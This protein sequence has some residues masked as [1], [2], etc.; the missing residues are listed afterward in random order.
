MWKHSGFFQ[1]NCLK[2]KQIGI[3]RSTQLLNLE[4]EWF[5]GSLEIDIII[6]GLY[7]TFNSPESIGTSRHRVLKSSS[8]EA[9]A[10]AFFSYVE[11]L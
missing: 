7:S 3:Q 11:N 2:T 6:K 8:L 5:R 4:N 9:E 1:H 10:G